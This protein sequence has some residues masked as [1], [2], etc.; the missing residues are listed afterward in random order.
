M[1]LALIGYPALLLMGAVSAGL[2]ALMIFTLGSI[3][4]AIV[5]I[6]MLF[7]DE[8]HQTLNDKIADT[9]IVTTK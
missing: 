4:L 1:L 6:V 3:V 7:A 9:V 5:N 8:R 2:G